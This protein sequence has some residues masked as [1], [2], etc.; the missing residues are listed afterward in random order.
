MQDFLITLR[1]WGHKTATGLGIFLG[2]AL[3]MGGCATRQIEPINPLSGSAPAGRISIM[4][5]N[6]ENL[7]DATHDVGKKDFQYLPLAEKAK[8][9]EAKAYC[10]EQRGFYLKECKEMDW[11]ES[12]IHKKLAAVADGILQVHGKGPDVLVLLEVENINILNRL[13][14]EALQAAGYQTAVLIEGSDVR[15]VD[16]GFLSRLPLADA[17]KLHKIEFTPE[18]L[19]KG[20]GSATRGILEVPLKLPTGETLTVFGVHLPSQANPVEERRDAVNHLLRLVKAKGT[21]A[22]WV[23]GGDWN[24][25]GLEDDE[26]GMISKQ[27]ASQAL[28]SHLVGCKKCKGSHAYRGG[29]S[30]LDILAF[31][32]TFGEKGSSKYELDTKSIRVLQHGK[33]QMQPN[34]R[35]ARFDLEKEIGISDHLPIY[36]EIKLREK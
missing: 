25:T 22:L 28:V 17:P 2:L 7:F 26:T 8:N 36:S 6:V 33:I 32:K 16:V 10:A 3:W 23:I 12:A 34:G 27:V 21:D 35:P 30:F 31:A 20:R 24:I 11:T 13:N 4:S 15:G 19:T 5:Y 29:W 14:R 18:A 9:P 1:T